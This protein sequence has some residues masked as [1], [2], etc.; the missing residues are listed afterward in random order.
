MTLGLCL[1]TA[2]CCVIANAET[3]EEYLKEAN[4]AEHAGDF[5]QSARFYLQAVD[6]LRSQ[7]IVDERR[8]AEALVSL[9]QAMAAQGRRAEAKR[10]FQQALDIRRRILGDNDIATLTTL[11]YVASNCL[12]MGDD[13]QARALFSESA[14][15]LRANYPGSIQLARALQGVAAVQIWRGDTDSAAPFAEEALKIAIAN[16][17]QS[18]VDT[19][20]AYSTVAL[21]HLAARRTDRALP[22]YRKSL[23][24]YERA[25]GPDNPRVAATRSQLALVLIVDG[26]LASAEDELLK[27]Q[28]SL[29][30]SCPRCDVETCNIE[31]NLAMLRM[32]EG[33]LKEADRLLNHVLSIQ[34]SGGWS[35]GAISATL[36]SLD[37]I[38][39][40]TT[41]S[42]E[43]VSL[44][45][46][47]PVYR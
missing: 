13:E 44:R 40:R 8:L 45:G 34:Q 6:Q 20:M 22:L 11:N 33:N 32:R 35:S 47:V 29:S 3:A 19:A 4:R 31:T 28:N 24:I 43:A 36:K 23:A 15:R 2:L 14:K 1:I 25:L 17:G 27:A 41:K 38:R 46:D 18:S 30:A 26:K 42:K 37:Q 16:E 5:V 7:R 21:H 10:I 39:Q 12:S 9:G